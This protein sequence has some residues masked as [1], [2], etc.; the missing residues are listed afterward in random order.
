[1]SKQGLISVMV[2]FSLIFGFS[3]I[4]LKQLLDGD[5]PVWFLLAFRFCFGALLLLAFRRAA[6]APPFDRKTLKAGVIVGT[7]IFFAY[8]VQTFGLQLTTP[9]KNG[10][11]TG[12][13]VIFVPCA[14]MPLKKKFSWKPLLTAPLSFAGAALISGVFGAELNLNAGD[15]LTV[16]GALFFALHLILLE[17]F[18]PALPAL[19]FTVIQ[20]GTVA[21]LSAA[22]SL[23]VEK[24]THAALDWPAVLP[25]LLF[26]TVF[27]TGLASFFQTFVQARLPASTTAVILCL[28]S[29]FAVV[30]S[31]LFGYDRFTVSFGAGSALIIAAMLLASAGKQEA[32]LGDAKPAP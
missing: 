9:A 3:F 28:E 31:V 6:A 16:C 24:G 4:V 2:L 32:L 7:A 10:L 29:V 23:C 11:F 17:R 15:A 18:A 19:N 21:L 8:A 22:A 12:L 5:F 13:Y 26:L 1:M 30:F 25:G 27:A 14:M 20:L